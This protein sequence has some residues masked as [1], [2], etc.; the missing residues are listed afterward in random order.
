MNQFVESTSHFLLHCPIYNNDRSSL[1]STIKNIDCKLLKITEV[2]ST[3]HFLFYCPIYNNDRSFL[4]STIRNID[5]KLLEITDSSL[6]QTS[7][8]G[9]PSFDFITNSLIL[10]ATID[11]ILSTERFKKALFER[12]NQC[13]SYFF[14]NNESINLLFRQGLSFSIQYIYSIR[15]TQLM[16]I[17]VFKNIQLYQF[18]FHPQIPLEYFGVWSGDCKF[19]I[20]YMSVQNHN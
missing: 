18:S 6:T 1:L 14:L 19:L 12:N 17:Y 10:N 4:L 8:Y 2:E 5:C 3:S 20:Q 9:N 13:F 16:Y 11:F 7:L 15:N